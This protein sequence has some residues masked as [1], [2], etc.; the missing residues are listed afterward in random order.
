M[1]KKAIALFLVK[2]LPTD[3]N[4]KLPLMKKGYTTGQCQ[5][6][7]AKDVFLK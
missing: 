4:V 6:Q 5:Q 3:W 7:S 2:S 1:T